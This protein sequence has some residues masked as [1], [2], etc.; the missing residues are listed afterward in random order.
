MKLTNTQNYVHRVHVDM[1]LL[2][3]MLGQDNVYFCIIRI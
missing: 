1:Q 3:A 2:F